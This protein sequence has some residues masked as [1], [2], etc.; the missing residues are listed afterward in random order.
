MAG[1]KSSV[2]QEESIVKVAVKK[3]TMDGLFWVGEHSP[4]VTIPLTG[5]IFMSGAI[6]AV[7]AATLIGIDLG[8]NRFFKHKRNKGKS[9]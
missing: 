5:V 6:G 2:D 8:Q 9:K 1:E 3:K 4:K 7:A